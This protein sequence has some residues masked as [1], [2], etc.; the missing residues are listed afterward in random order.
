MLPLKRVN[1]GKSVEVGRWDHRRVQQGN[2]YQKALGKALAV[3]ATDINNNVL[4]SIII[5]NDGAVDLLLA[6]GHPDDMIE[7][8]SP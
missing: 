6:N 7:N 4:T 3:V 2:R 8:Y 1:K 5:D